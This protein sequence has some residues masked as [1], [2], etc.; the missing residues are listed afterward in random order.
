MATIGRQDLLATCNLPVA[1]RLLIV[2]LSSRYSE[3]GLQV[4][5]RPST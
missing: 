2:S 1:Q 3:A 4:S 5:L